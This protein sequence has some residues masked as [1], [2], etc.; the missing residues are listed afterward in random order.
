MGS[1]NGQAA[2][3][4]WLSLKKKGKYGIR[5]E[6]EYCCDLARK[7]SEL[8]D[9]NNISHMLNKGKNFLFFFY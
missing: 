1:R 9:E 6:V 3:F 2:L 5:K 8:L 4:M 7:F